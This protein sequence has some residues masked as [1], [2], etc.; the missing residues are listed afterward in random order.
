M[1][2]FVLIWLDFYNLIIFDVIIILIVRWIDEIL[3]KGL[4]IYYFL[5]VIEFK[6]KFFI[7]LIMKKY[8]FKS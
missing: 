6:L 2:S 4:I 3:F 5:R 8:F 7:S 1:Y